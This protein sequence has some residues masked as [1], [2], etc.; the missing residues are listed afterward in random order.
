MK[1]GKEMKQGCFLCF[2]NDKFTLSVN[3]ECISLQSRQ[4]MH[5]SGLLHVPR[6]GLEPA[7]L[8]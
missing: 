4:E 7:Q 5:S 6:A 3:E 8:Q 1:I 2:I